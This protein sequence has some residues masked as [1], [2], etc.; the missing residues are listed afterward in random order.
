M[1]VFVFPAAALTHS[2]SLYHLLPATYA[3]VSMVNCVAREM[4][5]YFGKA[6][7][8]VSA[9]A[10][11]VLQRERALRRR[12]PEKNR[13]YLLRFSPSKR[14]WSGGLLKIPS[15]EATLHALQPGSQFVPLA[16][17][18]RTVQ[19]ELRLDDGAVVE[20]FEHRVVASS[21]LE[22]VK[23]LDAF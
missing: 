5:T 13:Q 20:P 18:N 8:P 4:E 6:Q 21:F 19:Y 14:T 2:Q 3:S 23:S 10:S 22:F 1:C 11:L 7:Q 15:L 12:L 16:I 17:H 9:N